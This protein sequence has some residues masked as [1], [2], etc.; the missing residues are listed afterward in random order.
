MQGISIEGFAFWVVD[1]E[2]GGPLKC[3]NYMEGGHANRHV[4][5]LSESIVRN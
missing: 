4:Q 1:R 2:K 5:A 3:Y